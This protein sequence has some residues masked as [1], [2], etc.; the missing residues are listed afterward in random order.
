M[1]EQPPN[2]HDLIDL[3]IDGMLPPEEAARFE[4]ALETDP[5]LRRQLEFQ[6]EI[7]RSLKAQFAPP[8]PETAASIVTALKSAGPRTFNRRLFALA[9]MLALAAGG[10]FISQKYF[11]PPEIKRLAPGLVYSRLATSGWPVEF[12][13]AD[14]KEFASV[15]LRQLGAPLFIPAETPGVVVAGWSYTGGYD[16]SVL[17]P[18]TMFLI[19]RVD[20]QPVLVLLDKAQFDRELEL[21]PESNLH[22]HRRELQG[23]IM[24]EISPLTEPRVIGAMREMKP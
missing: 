19:T 7:D 23:V 14:E 3:Y 1:S 4:A 22:L 20:Q 18:S 21:P 17:G 6:G 12:V 8:A 9:A 11:A 2:V 10:F 5:D 24:Y 16:G 15:M 13:C